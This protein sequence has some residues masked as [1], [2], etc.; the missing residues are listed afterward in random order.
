M[1]DP[2]RRFIYHAQSFL[3]CHIPDP[4]IKLGKPLS[5]AKIP[6]ENDDT[7]HHGDRLMFTDVINYSLELYSRTES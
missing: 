2:S 5:I 3:T 6:F 4:K 1:S 7:H